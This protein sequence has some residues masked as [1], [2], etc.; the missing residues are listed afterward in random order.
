MLDDAN[1]RGKELQKD[2]VFCRGPRQITILNQVVKK[3]ND[4]KTFQQRLVWG[5]AGRPRFGVWIFARLL[6]EKTFS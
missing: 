4:R 1:C 5:R 6:L 2:R 3:C